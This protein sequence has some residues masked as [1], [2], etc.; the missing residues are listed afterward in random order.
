MKRLVSCTGAP[1]PTIITIT[2]AIVL[3]Q[4]KKV[5]YLWQQNTGQVYKGTPEPQISQDY[6]FSMQCT[7]G[8]TT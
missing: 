3:S 6:I 8:L 4:G 2:V 5:L 7:N 1:T